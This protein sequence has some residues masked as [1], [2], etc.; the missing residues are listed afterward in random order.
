MISSLGVDAHISWGESGMLV[1]VKREFVFLN[2]TQMGSLIGSKT[3]LEIQI[4]RYMVMQEIRC[5]E[6]SYICV[7]CAHLYLPV[8]RLSVFS[9]LNALSNHIDSH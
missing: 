8:R 1:H 5:G 3:C 7:S 2:R 9:K 6:N 4:Y